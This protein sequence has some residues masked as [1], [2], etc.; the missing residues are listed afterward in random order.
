[1]TERFFKAAS[2]TLI[3]FLI[4]VG[5]FLSFRHKGGVVFPDE[6]E[7]YTLA[8][9]LVKYHMLTWDGVTPTAS[10]PPGFVFWL[11]IWKSIGISWSGLVWINSIVVAGALWMLTGKWFSPERMWACRAAT[12]GL[13]FCYPVSLYVFSTLYPQ[14]FCLTLIAVSLALLIGWSGMWS[15]IIAGLLMGW[16]ALS[17]PMYLTWVG[18]LALIPILN[19]GKEGIVRALV[20][21]A[22]A[23]L[24]IGSWGTRNSVVMQKFVPFSTN[25]GFNLLIGNSPNTRPNAGLN[26]DTSKYEN[27]A[28]GLSEVA[29]DAFYSQEAKKWVLENPARSISMYCQKFLNYFNYRN[30]L[31]TT[32]AGSTGRD[33][34]MF[35][36]YYG[37]MAVLIARFFMPSLAGAMSWRDGLLL[38]GYLACAMFTAVVVTRIRYRVPC[39]VLALL[40]IAPL[41]AALIEKSIA[42]LSGR[43]RAAK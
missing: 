31:V 35:V 39:D 28:K 20:F 4:L 17:A 1:M 21:G 43:F 10:R 37:L 12:F 3:T 29:K 34:L 13:L 18:I 7:Y 41:P 40:I 26:I 2:Y 36:T 38:L 24:A 25:S 22:V 9:N 42:Y 8:E 5:A 27:E 33:L 19:A 30:E 23:A 6:K 14:A 32:S 16:C 15:T 11:A